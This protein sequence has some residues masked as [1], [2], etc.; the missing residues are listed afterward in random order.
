MLDMKIGSNEF[1]RYQRATDR[2]IY[3]FV[4]TYRVLLTASPAGQLV[5][6]LRRQGMSYEN[7]VAQAEREGLNGTE[8]LQSAPLPTWLYL[9]Q[10]RRGTARWSD[11][12]QLCSSGGFVLAV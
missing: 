2:G 11:G 9:A 1:A 5:K 8:G 6:K 3:D 10:S 7:A 12:S 4:E